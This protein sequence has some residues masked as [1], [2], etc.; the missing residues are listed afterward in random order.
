MTEVLS[1]APEGPCVTRVLLVDDSAIALSIL[2]RMLA[3]APDIAVAGTARDGEEALGLVERLDPHVICTDLHMPGMDGLRFT[4]EVM[5]RHPRPILVVSVSVQ[6]GQ[7][8]VFRL[9]EA[10]A[11]DVFPKPRAGL[12]EEF[13]KRSDDLK[14]RIRI[15]AGV[16]VFR[17]TA[18]VHAPATGKARTGSGRPDRPFRIV[19]IG[20]STGG[21]QAL[22]TIFEG[23]P[24][25][26]PAPVVCV[27]HIG[28]EFL[29][30]MVEWLNQ[31]CGPRF[32]IAEEGETLQDGVVYFPKA[33]GHLLLSR[34]RRFAYSMDAPLNGHRPSITTTFKSIAGVFKGS[35]IGVLLTGMGSDGAEGIKEIR[36]AGGFTIAQDEATSIVFSMP[37]SA[38]ELDAVNSILPLGEIAGAIAGMAAL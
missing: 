23:L 29:A 4:R 8:N 14:M 36:D 3:G 27:Q 22:K 18:G 12:E 13:L 37:R 11:L 35:A 34:D 15:L 38:I 19:A 2:S 26:F 31:T 21:P 1:S 20:A 30:G 25:R 17:R 5:M 6:E 28:G 10:G 24:A 9:L 33:D 16:R 7:D 32:K